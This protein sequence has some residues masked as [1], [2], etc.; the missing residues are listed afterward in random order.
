MGTIV[1]DDNRCK[2][3]ELCT[4]VC[5]F[6]LVHMSN[7][8]SPK[9]YRLSALVDAEKKCTACTLCARMCPDLAII[10]YR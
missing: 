3:C 5:P 6:D 2:G 4:T 10:V 7:R 1:I 8:L 9:G